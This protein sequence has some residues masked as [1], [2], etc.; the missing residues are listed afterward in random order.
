MY[1]STPDRIVYSSSLDSVNGCLSA[2]ILYYN[3]YNMYNIIQR[4]FC[5]RSNIRIFVLML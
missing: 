3:I 2:H 1:A 4:Q 5:I